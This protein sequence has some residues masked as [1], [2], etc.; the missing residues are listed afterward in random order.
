[1]T[2]NTPCS[3]NHTSRMTTVLDGQTRIRNDVI[4]EG[5]LRNLVEGSSH[6][7]LK[8]LGRRVVCKFDC[9]YPTS[10]RSLSVFLM[11]SDREA[12]IDAMG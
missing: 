6:D 9:L 7:A 5:V 11:I 1:M 12:S 2:L 3:H 8:W 4:D 10:S